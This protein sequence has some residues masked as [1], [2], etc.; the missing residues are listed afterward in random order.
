MGWLTLAAAADQITVIVTESLLFAPLREAVRKRSRYLGELVS[1]FLC[2]GTWVG[3]A[4]ALVGRGP[5]GIRR[6]KAQGVVGPV[7]AWALDG[8]AIAF[9]ARV[10][11][12][13][14]GKMQREVRVLD[15]QADVLERTGTERPGSEFAQWSR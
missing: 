5:L 13:V 7:I 15:E 10:L 3:L 2:F 6:R 1:C 12:E 4:L 8:L 14:T 11:N 9:T